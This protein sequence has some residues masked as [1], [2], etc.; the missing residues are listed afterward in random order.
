VLVPKERVV[1]SFKKKKK[2]PGGGLGGGGEK[3]VYDYQG[4]TDRK[5]RKGVRLR[6][7]RGNK[8]KKKLTQRRATSCL[9][10]LV[11]R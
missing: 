11:S 5:R 8:R 4:K 10:S 2:V 3:R 7:E 9:G 1:Y 6:R